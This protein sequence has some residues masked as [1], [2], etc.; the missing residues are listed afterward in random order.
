MTVRIKEKDFWSEKIPFIR[1]LKGFYSKK[2]Y[3]GIN[4]WPI[5]AN[6]VYTYYRNQEART[7][8]EIFLETVKNLF[9]LDKLKV[10]GKRARILATYFMARKDH[11][12]L[13][14]KSISSFKREEL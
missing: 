10:N 3:G 6:D 14:L 13:F 12:E 2:E 7:K 1:K 5:M 11:H 9:L 8:K 4:L